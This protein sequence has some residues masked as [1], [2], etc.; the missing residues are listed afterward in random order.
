M[1]TSDFDYPLDIALVAQHPS[2]QR[3]QSRLLVLRRRDGRVSD[4]VFSELPGILK[5]GDLLVVND[6]AVIPARFLCRRGG[7]GRVDGLFLRELSPGR[8]EVMLRNAGRCRRG[9]TL[10]VEASPGVVVELGKRLGEGRYE[11]TV[12]P[13]RLA[14]DLLREFGLPPLP[15]YIRRAG[16]EHAAADRQRYQTVYAARPGAVAAP[17]AGLHFTHELLAALAGKGIHTAAVTLHVGVGTFAPVKAEDPIA[18]RMHAEWYEL[19]ASTAEAV[20]AARREGRRVV[21]VGTTSLRVLET[22]GVAGRVLVAGS[23]WTELFV[24]PPARFR[25]VDALITNF[26]LP[27]TTLLMLVAAFCSPGDEKGL[28]RVRAAYAHAS[29]QRY[30]FYSYGD[31]MLIQ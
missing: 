19:P 23:G 29:A 17:T 26:H 5:A 8:W 24:Y 20:Q 4:H 7:G 25:V 31:A 22:A 3:D 2:A 16:G 30:R 15:P 28:E 1:K 18:H 10:T 11:L 6:T 21:A 14:L 9:E 13:A 27:R 12:S